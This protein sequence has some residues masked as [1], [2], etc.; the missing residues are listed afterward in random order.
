MNDGVGQFNSSMSDRSTQREC[1]DEPLR[2]IGPF[3]YNDRATQSSRYSLA[4]AFLI[5]RG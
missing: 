5:S 3:D 1:Q 2:N 4:A